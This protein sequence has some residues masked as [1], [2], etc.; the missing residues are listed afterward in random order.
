MT[1]TAVASGNVVQRWDDSFFKEYIR[2][3]GFKPYMGSGPMSIIQVREDFTAKKGQTINIPLVTRLKGSGVTGNA[4]LEGN[5]EAL[6]N[7]NWP[8]T[9]SPLR[10]GVVVDEWEEQKTEIDL[11][12]AAR[13][14]LLSWRMDQLRGGIT[15]QAIDGIIEA[16]GA[17]YDGTT[18]S[19]FADA[20]ETAKDTW[21]SNNTDR[22]LF[23][24]TT[25]NRESD[26]DF[27]DSVVKVDGT[28][29]KF[30][31]DALSLMKRMARAADPHIRPVRKGSNG[32]EFF[33]CF[34]ASRAFRDFKRSSEMTQANR[35]AR[36]RD[37]ES[38]PLFQDGDLVWDGVIVREIP[39]IPTIS[40][41][42]AG[43]INV[44]P[45]HL[46]GAQALGL[47]WGQRPVSRTQKNDYG[48]RN[49]VATQEMRGIRKN[50]WNSKQ[51]GVVSGFFA[52]E[53]D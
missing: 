30:T 47:V 40:G 39:E 25:S 20:T 7:Y 6:G 22:V 16:L 5:E 43:G 31:P 29:D 41:V 42:G 53:A 36:P 2:D 34:A 45:V 18:Y 4:V 24:A 28:A 26:N 52:G 46:C 15:G 32:R 49:G 27:S 21:V 33:V 3:S 11:R 38:N 35:E 23:G 8:I 51:H 9:I 37:V 17:I 14:M 13:D 44:D 10:H 12:N 1:D 48:F 50:F 19:N